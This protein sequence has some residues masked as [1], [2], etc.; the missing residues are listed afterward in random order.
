MPDGVP[1]VYADQVSLAQ[2]PFG[3]TIT[4][5]RTVSNPSPS[6]PGDGEPQVTVRMSLEHAKALA[7]ILRRN[8][9]QY[10]LETL[11]D[12][13]PLPQVVLQQLRLTAA[14]W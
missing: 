14:D 5:S 2:S 13:I 1:D 4:F 9:K 6:R 11:G 7:M 3:L 12:S 10:E 8:L